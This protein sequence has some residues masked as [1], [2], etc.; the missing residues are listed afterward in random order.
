M[1]CDFYGN[2]DFLSNIHFNMKDVNQLVILYEEFSTYISLFKVS[3]ISSFHDYAVLSASVLINC[4]YIYF[5]SYRAVLSLNKLLYL[6]SDG[7]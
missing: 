5:Y 6:Q 7:V 1:Y 4:C 2:L 3:S